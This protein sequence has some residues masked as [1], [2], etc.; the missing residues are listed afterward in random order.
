MIHKDSQDKN[1]VIKVYRHELKFLLS[2]MEYHNLKIL[3]GALL[4]K[5]VHMETKQDYYIRSLYFD[6]IENQDYVGKMIGM[7]DRKKIRLRLYD[8][9]AETVKLEIKN[10]EN[11][12]SLKETA[13]IRRED[14]LQLSMCNYQS[15]LQ[16]DDA[17]SRKVYHTFM[18]NAYMPKVIVDYEREAYLL[19]VENVR[20]TFDKDVRAVKS[21]DLFTDDLSMKAVMP[22]Q[23]VILEV[24]YDKYLPDYVK[25]VLSSV[26]MQRMSISKYCM[27]R[28][29]VG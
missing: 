17:V 5:D 13:T 22:T 2:K 7:P 27:A 28:E 9:N 25:Q 24:K 26:Y 29:M 1:G 19:P 8:V 6:S 14:A 21:S 12:Y 18:M 23:Y 11:D 10:K 20:L 15:M 16:Y 4:S 3:L